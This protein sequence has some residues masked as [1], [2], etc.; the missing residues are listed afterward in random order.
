[1]N[2]CGSNDNT[3]Y[4]KINNNN[5]ERDETELI[6]QGV[7]IIEYAAMTIVIKSELIHFMILTF[8]RLEIYTKKN[9]SSKSVNG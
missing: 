9:S 1:M 5:N 6:L 8:A 7:N 2:F 4:D 3:K